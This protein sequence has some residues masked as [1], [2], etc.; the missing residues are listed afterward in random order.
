MKHKEF[1]MLLSLTV[2]SPTNNSVVFHESAPSITFSWIEDESHA[3]LQR[4]Q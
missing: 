2:N 4:E 1:T 3:R